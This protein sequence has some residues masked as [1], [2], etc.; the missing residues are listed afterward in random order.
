MK[1]YEIIAILKEIRKISGE[2]YLFGNQD[3]IRFKL[4]LIKRYMALHRL[5]I[6][7]DL[8]DTNLFTIDGNSCLE[9][10]ATTTA[11]LISYMEDLAS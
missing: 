1:K 4:H 11:L 5:I 7:K 10:I 6:E 3:Q 2:V 8:L 9:D